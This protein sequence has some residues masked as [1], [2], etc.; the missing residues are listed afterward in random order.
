MTI[1]ARLY[2]MIRLRSLR[3]E[4][5][6]ELRILRNEYDF[7]L[8]ASTDE[9]EATVT[10]L[11]QRIADLAT[12][13][14]ARTAAV[15]DLTAER[16]AYQNAVESWRQA[17]EAWKNTALQHPAPKPEPVPAQP[18][19]AAAPETKRPYN[20]G[21]QRRPRYANIADHPLV[22]DMGD[23]MAD[24]D[25]ATFLRHAGWFQKLL[26]RHGY[27][28]DLEKDRQAVEVILRRC[29]EAKLMEHQTHRGGGIRLGRYRWLVSPEEWARTYKLGHY[30]DA[31][32][33]TAT[34]TTVQ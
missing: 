8:R 13:L 22:Q 30:A 12:E 25:Q 33:D 20:N 29:R 34:V 4:H 28:P 6:A 23:H 17:A 10:V 14:E 19:P 11:R 27:H 26:R 1:L 7:I 24:H 2:D 3:D 9:H 32:C 5:A 15:T 16:D 21:E 31:A 18:E